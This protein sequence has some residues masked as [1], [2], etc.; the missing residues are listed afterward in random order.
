MA[1]G[2]SVNELMA[3]LGADSFL[4]TQRNSALGHGNTNP[5]KAYRQQAA[6]ALSGEG[7]S[8]LSAQLQSAYDA[9]GILPRDSLKSLDWP[10]RAGN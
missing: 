3:R 10:T 9:H 5:R 8:W 1:N 4:P 6:V 7:F 2:V